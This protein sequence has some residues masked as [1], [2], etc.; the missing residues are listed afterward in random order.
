MSNLKLP[1]RALTLGS[2][3]SLA[4]FAP[5]GFGVTDAMQLRA[6]EPY[7]QALRWDN[8]DG[9]PFWVNGNQPVYLGDA[10]MHGIHLTPGQYSIIH[11]PAYET[12]R[13]YAPDKAL[14]PESLRVYLS[15]GSGLYVERSL[16][17]ATDGKSWL[18]S[19][20]AAAASLVYIEAREAQ[21]FAV[22]VSRREP[23][24]EVAP[25]PSFIALPAELVWLSR[26]S[27][28]LPEPYWQLPAH[29]PQ[30]ISVQGPARLLLR[31]R[32]LY[33]AEASALLQDYRVQYRIDQQPTQWLDFATGVETAHLI[34]V[35]ADSKV[36][37][38]EQQGFVEIPAGRHQ[39]E[40]QPD[41]TLYAQ[42][43]MQS[44]RD[45]LLPAL[46]QPLLPVQEIRDNGALPNE[47]LTA[48]SLASERQARDNSRRDSAMLAQQLLQHAALPRPDYPHG[49][50]ETEQMRGLR[51]FYRDLPPTQKASARAQFKAYFL[52]KRIKP[53]NLA[54]EDAQLA[55]Q[56]L[57]A[58]L[59]QTPGALFTALESENNEY[60]LPERLTDS[61]LRLVVDKSDCVARR[62][63]LQIDQNPPVAVRLACNDELDRDQLQTSLSEA[64]LVHLHANVE[65]A[66][67]QGLFNAYQEPGPLIAA[68]TVE[69]PLPAQ[70]RTVTIR[71]A[72][73]LSA[74]VNVA[75]QYR[76]ARPSQLSEQSYLALLRN[77][78][79]TGQFFAQLG[80]DTQAEQQ[81]LLND[82]LPL[83]RLIKAEHGLFAA[84]IAGKQPTVE[85]ASS[86]QLAEWSARAHEQEGQQQWQSA[87][88][89]W[90]LIVQHANAETQ[91]QAR[92]AQAALLAKMGE[93]Y[94]A[95][96]LW[97]Y[98]SL[99][100]GDE[101][102][103]QAT[104]ALVSRYQQQN[105]TFALQALRAARLQ[106]QPS[107]Q[108][109][110]E[111]AQALLANG[112]YRFVLLL[113]L[114]NPE[115]TA[116]DSQL[117]AAYQLEW[118]QTYHQLL[119]KLPEPQRRF[120]LGLK[121]QKSGDYV[122]ADQLWQ[123]EE[124]KP[125]R[126]QLNH[127]LAL[128]QSTDKAQAALYHG[129]WADWL[130]QHP[131]D[132]VW[133][134]AL[135]LVADYAGSDLYYAPERDLYATAFRGTAERPV[136]LSVLGPT[137]LKLQI[138]PLHPKQQAHSALNGW[139][140]IED[141]QQAQVYPFTNNIPSQGLE[142]AG[143]D[144]FQPG[145]LESLDYQ[146]GAGWHAIRLHSGQAPL[147]ISV[148]QSQPESL[149]SVLPTLRADTFAAV[150]DA[151]KPADQAM[152]PQT[153]SQS[154]AVALDDSA[155]T[156]NVT[157][158]PAT[159]LADAQRRVI[160][161]AWLLE[162]NPDSNQF[163]ALL[164]SARQL[165]QQFPDDS[166]L[167]SL[168]RRL[169]SYSE[170]QTVNSVISEAG[171]RFVKASGW[172]PE[173]PEQQI[174]KALM[175]PTT[176]NDYALAGDERL[177]LSLSNAAAKSIEFKLRL[178][179][180][181]F[182]P[183]VA[184]AVLYQLDDTPPQRVPL[185]RNGD[186]L[187]LKLHLPS[188][189]HQLRFHVETP[190]VNQ[191]VLLR[192]PATSLDLEKDSER[193]YFVTTP[194]QPVQAYVNGPAEIRIDEWRQGS[195]E[196]RFETVAAGWQT[197]SVPPGAGQAESL[198]RVRQRIK[199]FEGPQT[200]D[201]RWIDRMIEPVPPADGMPPRKQTPEKIRLQ[202]AFK[203]G[204]Q[205][206]GTWSFGADLVRRNNVQEDTGGPRNPEQF[207]N[208]RINHRYFDDGINTWW[209]T[210][211]L[212]HHREHGNPT[213][214]IK[215]SISFN[216]ESVPINF[217]FDLGA[218]VQDVHDASLHD[219][220]EWQGYLNFSA[221]HKYTLT[222]K[223]AFIPQV[224]FFARHLSLH[225][226]RN[227]KDPA[228]IDQD[229]Y[230]PYKAD[231]TSGMRLSLTAQHKPW[232]DTL[233]TGNFGIVS[234][235]IGSLARSAPELLPL[236]F[237]SLDHLH[238]EAHWKQ[239]IG[240]VVADFGYRMNFFQQDNDRFSDG[241]S[242]TRTRSQFT[243]DLNWH[244]WMPS[245]Q[246]LEISGQYMYDIQRQSHLAML[247]F[248]LH[249]GE[250][251]GYRDFQP[252]EIDFENIRQRPIEHGQNNLF[253]DS[254]F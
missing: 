162:R 66:T 24:G 44:E 232:L 40:L 43:L 6:L 9:H 126:E 175:L 198:V 206:N 56:H 229:V 117:K 65:P 158:L 157:K 234:N 153:P 214:G 84:S 223:T 79:S 91:D 51:T 137:K 142:I 143:S 141:N 155:A 127:G 135:G 75:L 173:N 133:R 5:P 52:P 219:N 58:A 187:P 252:G 61:Q 145:S 204:R 74:A 21:E 87:L 108:R 89:S 189:N 197:L 156:D 77:T 203:L 59:E 55:E 33:E 106:T 123:A 132:F 136:T 93:Y 90:S 246:L 128:Q 181:D 41:R 70:A 39:L 183:P 179:D 116:L 27:L 119:E 152:V 147:S 121:A 146:V 23:V 210:Q 4:L 118:W 227:P 185:N 186:W 104:D 103:Q 247:S 31:N 202:D 192:V 98:L 71:A 63:T 28:H 239:L 46:N 13:L 12:L 92:F 72:D 161:I 69:L 168:W 150:L 221:A 167:Q 53:L 125:W 251:R 174:R 14:N 80:R 19:P 81:E 26:E 2:L 207:A 201:N 99:Y 42:M 36:T 20:R 244:H 233:W 7:Q 25:Y 249:F 171:M 226:E 112:E 131:G 224:S 242:G 154:L 30:R 164:T 110:A 140:E 228:E 217:N 245:R 97:R 138:R 149:L 49:R 129:R 3:L 96:S 212:V 47:N 45:Y 231:H 76:S 170:W 57:G 225:G 73:G 114:A 211:A 48:T 88:S 109:G 213:V 50:E 159:T 190:V 18:L 1:P 101:V 54:K 107:A 102:A 237:T 205:E 94:L 35:N 82:W 199:R 68:A 218:F 8:V 29:Q 37:G 188:G 122:L 184:G 64:A 230:T 177:V 151:N 144:A 60:G 236:S 163:T 10:H 78:P 220:T 238:T 83:L 216:P 196:S 111:L 120:W 95:D 115:H 130:Q 160:K 215:E 193:G 182:L 86:R 195:I 243:L 240:S 235:E 15:D 241:R 32:L 165:Q 100:A 180:V 178:A 11:L 148:E 191:Q 34:S 250:G 253:E 22:F 105:N 113:G 67:L 200:I 85:A 208:Y 62:L 169:S 16:Q 248:T 166:L 194:R 254:G 139:I 124:N 222:P 172:M 38:R 209:N 176:A 17:Q 134:E